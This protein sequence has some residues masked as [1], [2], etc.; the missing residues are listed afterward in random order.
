[1]YP[2][3]TMQG[4]GLIWLRI[5]IIIII[6]IIIIIMSFTSLMKTIGQLHI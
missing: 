4:I 6:I 2:I 1:M 5:G 3:W